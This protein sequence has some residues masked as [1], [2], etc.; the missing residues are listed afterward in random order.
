M[1]AM[2]DIVVWRSHPGAKFCRVG[3]PNGIEDDYELTWGRARADG[4][5]PDAF[6]AMDK[7]YPKRVA[8]PDSVSNNDQMV[9]VSRKLKEFVES[10]NPARVECLQVA[11]RD[12]R[13]RVASPDYFIINPLTIIECIDTKRSKLTWNAME[14]TLIAGVVDLVL[15]D[16]VEIEPSVLLFRPKHLETVVMLRADLGD[17][18]TAAGFTGARFVEIADFEGS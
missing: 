12:H 2:T 6:F 5:P 7:R 18:I 4:F 15:R 14:P 9:L 1:K 8:L 10:K 13:G 11:I 17:A 16:S 3:N